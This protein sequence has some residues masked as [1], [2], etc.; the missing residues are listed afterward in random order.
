M[1]LRRAILRM[2]R[3]HLG[4]RGKEEAYMDEE[5]P[6]YVDKEISLE[7]TKAIRVRNER[8][9]ADQRKYIQ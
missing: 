7:S 2:W 5:D 8:R 9:V 1:A 4:V 3:L 6:G